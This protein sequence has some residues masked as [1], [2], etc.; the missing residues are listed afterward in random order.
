VAG[1]NLAYSARMVD[2]ELRAGVLEI[3]AKQVLQSAEKMARNMK[4]TK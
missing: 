2:R 4:T 3:A 1:L